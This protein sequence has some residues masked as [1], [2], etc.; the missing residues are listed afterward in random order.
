M[1]QLPTFEDGTDLRDARAKQT[2]YRRLFE[3]SPLSIQMHGPDGRCRAANP[4]HDWLWNVSCEQ[5]AAWDLRSDPQLADAG[6][7]AVFERISAGEAQVMPAVWFGA[8]RVAPGGR[9]TRVD[10]VAFP[11]RDEA[12]QVA[13]VAVVHQ[14]V[15]ALRRS[16]RL[17]RG[18][19]DV[20]AGTLDRLARGPDLDAFIGHVLAGVAK[21]RGAAADDQTCGRGLARSAIFSSGLGSPLRSA[22]VYA[23]VP[24]STIRTSAS[25]CTI[26]R[27]PA[28]RHVSTWPPPA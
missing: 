17:A 6:V 26:T 25:S 16:E 28:P 1:K 3:Q 15:T 14:D 4:A 9:R 22:C 10:T 7:G 18:Q 12:G 13:E 21:Q 2:R 5:M 11:L 27:S 24:G 20:I 8:A 19:A 23:A